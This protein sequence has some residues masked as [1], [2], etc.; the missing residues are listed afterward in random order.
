MK[1][2]LLTCPFTGVEFEAMQD[3]NGNL[4]VINPLTGNIF[5]VLTANSCNDF[6]IDKRLFTHVETVTI[7]ETSDILGVS[8]Q[9]VGAIA[10]NKTIPPHTVKG[11]TVFLLS[12]VLEYK[13]NKKP[14]APRKA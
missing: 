4:H 1:T 11:Q 9:R 3:E 13:K 12:D 7:S 8:R 14:G 10:A 5:Y 2:I 6:I